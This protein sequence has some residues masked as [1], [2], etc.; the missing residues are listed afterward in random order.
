MAALP[1]EAWAAG[2]SLLPGLGAGRVRRLLRK[3]SASEAFA[4]CRSGDLGDVTALLRC[5]AADVGSL[6]ASLRSAASS[7]DVEGRWDAVTRVCG[8]VVFGQPGYPAALAEDLEPPPVLFVRGDLG[9]L[10]R[11]RVTVVGTRHATA[12][13][14][15]VA[16]DLGAHLATAGVAVVSGLA[17]GIDA[18]AHRGAVAVD[19]AAPIAVVG[20]GP[21]HPYPMANAGL[22]SQ[23]IERG[24]LL[25]EAPPGAAAEPWRFPERNKILAAL[26][27]LTVVVESRRRGGSM[28]TVDEAIARGRT[29][30]AIPGSVRSPASEGPN[31][32]L[33]EGG[34][35]PA[36]DGADVLSALGLET[37]GVLVFDHRPEPDDAGL[38]IIHELGAESL[39]LSGLVERLGRS[40]V[41]VARSVGWLEAAGWIRSDR[42]WFDLAAVRP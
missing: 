21:D 31:H 18:A 24:V 4:R 11:R 2:L 33:V 15:T 12:L 26:G 25:S 28:I 42:G 41:E 30:L 27:E 13:G 37:C 35:G 20:S 36:R 22:W 17:S 19:G 40:P 9:A 5:P 38:A 34:A 16:T 7:L 10:D 8:V 1:E 23:V 29:V 3:W 32:L 14:R 39:D 6:R